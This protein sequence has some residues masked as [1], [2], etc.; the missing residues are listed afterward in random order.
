MQ[1]KLLLPAAEAQLERAQQTLLQLT[2]PLL[3]LT[4]P[5][6][7]AEA[8]LERAQQKLLL[9]AAEAQLERAQQ[10]LLQLTLPLLQLTLPLLQLTLP[11]L[12]F[13]HD[14][15]MPPLPMYSHKQHCLLLAMQK[16]LELRRRVPLLLNV[17]LRIHDYVVYRL[18]I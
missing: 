1:Q 17:L 2:L 11:L 9:P 15:E 4:L 3:Q 8:Q 16:L 14:F 18:P 7:D 13:Q 12:H 6:P 10:T 5:L